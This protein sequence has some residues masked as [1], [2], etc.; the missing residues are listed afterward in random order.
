[1]D[2]GNNKDEWSGRNWQ[3]VNDFNRQESF[4]KTVYGLGNR[5]NEDGGLF[6]GLLGGAG[7][8][9]KI[10]GNWRQGRGS[11]TLIIA[12][13]VI[14]II[15][16]FYT[17][18]QLNNGITRSTIQRTKI[19]SVDFDPATDPLYMDEYGAVEDERALQSAAK[20]FHDQTGVIPFVYFTSTSI[21]PS[22]EEMMNKAEN[23]YKENFPDGDHFVVYLDTSATTC[24]AG[25]Y[26][27]DN[28]RSV[29]DKEALQIFNDY[30]QKYYKVRQT[31]NS[32]YLANTYRYSSERMMSTLPF[33]KRNMILGIVC[34]V[35]LIAVIVYSMMKKA[36]TA[37]A[38]KIEK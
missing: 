8:N 5:S 14:V 28:A 23:F 6:G 32:T 17:Q 38:K 7:G 30:L 12:V 10:G 11:M 13:L 20:F 9:G 24:V 33:S 35:V 22:E 2:N 25:T 26:V 34:I 18:I 27:G 16:T 36:K 3:N 19:E 37:E 15:Y 1:M 21:V 29:L 31:D 4:G